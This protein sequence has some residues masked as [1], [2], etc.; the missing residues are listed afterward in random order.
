MTD[1]SDLESPEPVEIKPKPETIAEN[2]ELSKRPK[3]GLIK[4]VADVHHDSSDGTSIDK[5]SPPVPPQEPVE[6]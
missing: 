3:K 6:G 5:K 1:D 4:Q 2:N